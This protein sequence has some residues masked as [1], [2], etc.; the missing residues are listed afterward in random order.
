MWNKCPTRLF[1]FSSWC[2]NRLHVQCILGPSNRE[3]VTGVNFIHGNQMLLVD[4]VSKM[5]T[6]R[7]HPV[8]KWCYGVH[9]FI[10]YNPHKVQ[11]IPVH[12]YYSGALLTRL[13]SYTQPSIRNRR[14]RLIFHMGIPILIR[15][16]FYIEK[17][18][19]FLWRLS[20][21]FLN[22]AHRPLGIEMS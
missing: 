18:P 12:I 10:E 13:A 19:I 9:V 14:D 3:V 4:R 21:E 6:H 20:L 11:H 16:H 7:K 22:A 1:T 8:A 17:A 5:G 15:Q 2:H